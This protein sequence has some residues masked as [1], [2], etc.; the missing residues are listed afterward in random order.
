MKH[1]RTT[2]GALACAAALAAAGAGFAACDG[3]S[4][5]TTGTAGAGG[6]GG[7]G[8]AQAA[9]PYEPQGC[10]FKVAARP[11][12]TDWSVGKTDVGATPNIRWVRLGLGGNVKAGAKGKSD[13]ATSMGFAWQ[14]DDGT[15]AS[16]VAWGD[17]PDPASWP[18]ANRASGVTW[19]TPAGS[20]N[21]TGDARMHEV[22]VCGL[23]PATTYYYRVGGGPAGSEAWSDVYSFTTAPS[24]PAAPVTLVFAGDSRGQD[25]DAWRLLQKRVV[26][27]GATM[28][29]FSGDVINFAPDQGE[30]EKWLDLAWKD[31]SGKPS[32]LA[33]V[34]TVSAHGNHENHTSLFYSNVVLPQD[35]DSY[36]EYAELFYSFDVGPAHL[37]VVD[38][39]YIVSPDE[40][41][42]YQ[43]VLTAWLEADLAAA[44]ANRAK[45]PWIIALHHHGE[46]SSSNHGDDADVLRGRAYFVPIWQKHHVDLVVDGHDHNYE[47]THVLAGP[48][49]A[50]TVESD[51]KNGTMYVVCAGTGAPAYSSG[52][53]AFTDVSFD[54]KSGEAVGFYGML[55]ITQ[56]EL[57]LE[58]YELRVDGT[59]PMI[60][61]YTF[62]K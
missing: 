31:E 35:V 48:A 55:K 26:L 57:K 60:D 27:S 61:T 50:P 56:A 21:G 30:W 40:D 38:D 41:P 19:L 28:Q 2:T 14:T 10:D 16:E 51:P 9:A 13:P 25:H 62:T 52:K 34:L 53:S 3:K 24:D 47:R 58:G 20:I 45:V 59:D 22:Y 54:Y 12:Y 5:E 6:T 44:N 33:Q 15:L 39:E 46:Y 11:E 43:D 1:V 8:G 17:S 18:A 36:P 49:D 29:L 37:V 7:A 4:G 23:T 32:S 42:A